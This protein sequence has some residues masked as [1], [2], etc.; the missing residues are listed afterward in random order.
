MTRAGK[1][2]FMLSI[3]LAATFRAEAQV[4]QPATVTAPQFASLRWLIGAWRGSGGQYPAFYE[5]YGWLNDS[6]IWQRSFPDST[7]T[8]ASDSSTV[9]I[10]AGRVTMSSGGRVQYDAIQLR[11]DTLRFARRGATVGGF[12][13]LRESA[14]LWIAVLD[15]PRGSTTP[16]IYRMARVRP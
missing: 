8:K 10:R 14:T 3:A 13:W 2:F 6:T 7:F 15:P 5:E 11:G 16:T 12:A 9:E 4:A 1:L